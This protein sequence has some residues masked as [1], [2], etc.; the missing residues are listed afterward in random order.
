MTTLLPNGRQQFIDANGN[1]LVAGTVTFYIPSTTTP[2]DT[3]QDAEQTALNTNPVV[4]DARGQATIYGSG[5][6]RQ[7][8]KDAAGNVIW[9]KYLV[10]SS[11]DYTGPD[12]PGA[13]AGAYASWPDTANNLLKR[14]NATNT[15]W[16]VEGGLLGNPTNQNVSSLNG[17]PLAGMRNKLINGGFRV[18]QR[19]VSG[20]VA[21]AAGAYGHDRWKAGASGCTYTFSTSANVTTLTISAGSLMQ[22]V[23]GINLQSGQHVLSWQGTAQGRIDGGTYGASGVLGTAVGGTNQTIE[24][25][26]GT[27]AFVQYE[28][29]AIKTPFEQRFYDQELGL[30][31]RYYFRQTGNSSYVG[32]AQAISGLTVIVQVPLPVP[33]RT[34]PTINA[35]GIQAITASGSAVVANT[36]SDNGSSTRLFAASLGMASSSFVAGNAALVGFVSGGGVI[37]ANAEL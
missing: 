17:G 28:P 33:M 27:L 19:G 36:V 14:R 20:T 12:D 24:F 37:L 29:G 16:V 23:E 32:I 3:W 26:T 4:L 10:A 25:N 9:D 7:I 13:A 15:A 21:L 11:V 18:N 34:I 1:P 6:Y 30:C 2:K 8:L 5:A 35:S 31:Q 22:V